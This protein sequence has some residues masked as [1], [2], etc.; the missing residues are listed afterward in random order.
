VPTQKP[1]PDKLF[2]EILMFNNQ[3]Q[4]IKD[5]TITGVAIPAC[6]IEIVPIEVTQLLSPGLTMRDLGI[7]IHIVDEMYDSG[8][9]G[10]DQNLEVYN[11]RDIVNQ[12]VTGFKL[13]TGGAMMMRDE[14]Q[15][16]EHR[17]IYHYKVY[18]KAAWIDSTA[19]LYGDGYPFSVPKDYPR[20]D[21][22]IPDV[23]VEKQT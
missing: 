18:Y 11:Y 22:W 4:W 2:Q 17:N 21:G 12:W 13:E 16:Y 9:G 15:D 8:N 10:K 7:C 3:P 20:P 14:Q 19:S 5:G 23:T 6:Y 1:A